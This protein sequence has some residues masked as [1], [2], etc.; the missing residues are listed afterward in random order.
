ML[1]EWDESLSAGVKTIDA[2]HKRFIGIINSFREGILK[3]QGAEAVE[4]TI[5]AIS[6]HARDHFANEEKYAR[7]H[8]YPGNEDLVLEHQ[9][10]MK[11]VSDCSRRFREGDPEVPAELAGFLSDWLDD[12]FQSD[13]K[14]GEY[15]NSRG[16]Y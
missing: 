13:K 10:M 5:M 3:G 4:K 15:L 7:D 12:H 8:G 16:V 9:D 6:E 1:L 11:T 2:E 14:L